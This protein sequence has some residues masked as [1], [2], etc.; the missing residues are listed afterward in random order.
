[1]TCP[2]QL[3]AVYEKAGLDEVGLGMIG[4]DG[5]GERTRDPNRAW[6]E[7]NDWDQ[8]LLD[9]P[10]ERLRMIL[11]QQRELLNGA[12]FLGFGFFDPFGDRHRFPV[13][14]VERPSPGLFSNWGG[15]VYV[16]GR[17]GPC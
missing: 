10:V 11:G 3:T 1:M 6:T 14:I 13:V 17:P 8:T 16:C 2:C 5:L 9:H 7:P 4:A 12:V 15:F